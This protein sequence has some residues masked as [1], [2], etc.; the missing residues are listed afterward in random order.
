[1]ATGLLVSTLA[2]FALFGDPAAPWDGV[3]LVR[4]QSEDPAVLAAVRELAVDEWSERTAIGA[5]IDIA[6]AQSDLGILELLTG[7]YELLATDLGVLVQAEQTRLAS[8][9]ISPPLFADGH[10]DPEFFAEFRN[11]EELE[12]AWTEIALASPELISRK[13]IGV[14][15]EGRELW[16]F[17]IST[18]PADAP[19]I[20][21]NFGQHAREWIS[22][23]SAT[24]FLSQLV[25]NYDAD[26]QLQAL[27]SQVRLYIVPLVN[28]D[29]FDYTWTDDRFWRKNRRPEFGVDLNR[30]W[31]VSWGEE[32][33]SSSNPESGNYR[34]TGPFSEP[35]TAAVRAFA[36]GLPNLI[37]HVDV[38]SYSQLVL[39][40]LSYL[41]KEVP[42]TQGQAR[43]WAEEQALLMSGLYGTEYLPLRGSD[44][45]PATGV[46]M[47]WSFEEL[48]TMSFTYEL[49]PG[50]DIEFPDGF[51]LPPEEILPTCDEASAGIMALLDWALNGGP[52]A[53][54]PPPPNPPEPEESEGGDEGNA[55]GTDA[56]E[57]ESDPDSGDDESEGGEL[58]TGGGRLNQSDAADSAGCAC[59]TKAGE[60]EGT[61][62]FAGLGLVLMRRG[63]R[64]RR[65]SSSNTGA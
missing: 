36:V 28:P 12:Q 63:R 52:E 9:S 42:E 45:Y 35:E 34:G 7:E 58:G 1:M 38:H 30:N 5:P 57:S 26:N 62:W 18:A 15:Y 37:A 32:P 40:P 49:R 14:S 41:T 19:A 17:E 43:A 29:G 46:A 51:V 21:I 54:D 56:D 64:Q 31:S 22:P 33:G 16:A 13:Q 24:C 10:L 8:R 6:L 47:D 39:Y 4:V 48:G 59:S 55:D 23:A 11:L 27:F 3:S 20:F 50:T 44:L 61:F 2:L 25:D 65:L 53:V 60:D